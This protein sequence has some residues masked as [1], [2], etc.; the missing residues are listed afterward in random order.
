MNLKNTPYTFPLQMSYRVSFVSWIY[1]KKL[2]CFN[3]NSLLC[4]FYVPHQQSGRRD[5]GMA[6]FIPNF[7]SLSRAGMIFYRK[8][9]RSV[10]KKGK[11]IMY[12]IAKKIDGAIFPSLQGGPHQ[13]QIAA[14]AVA[15][16]QVSRFNSAKCS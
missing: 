15:L 7:F 12:D 14:I 8:G 10:D 5:I 6:L 11:E 16:K 9:I 13:H 2:M 1:Q 4:F 3:E